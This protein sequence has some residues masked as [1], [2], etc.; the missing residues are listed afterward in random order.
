MIIY[1]GDNE[2]QA[3]K[4]IIG[5]TLESLSKQD[6]DLYYLDCDL[7]NSCGTYGFWKNNP[8]R[9]INCGISEANMVGVAAGLSLLGKKVYAHTFGPFASRRCY[10]QLFLSIGYSNNNLRLIGSDP[11]VTAAYNGGTHMPFEDMA[12]LRAI[13][14]STVIEVSSGVML[15]KILTDI[16]DRQ[17][18]T[19]I[20]ST[21]KSYKVLYSEDQDFEIGK[22][23]VLQ[24][25]TDVTIVACGLMVSESMLAAKLLKDEGI[26][27]CVVDM[28]TV[29]PIDESLVIDCAKKT[30][31]L[32]TC[33]NHN[34]VGGLS[35]A[36]AKVLFES[37]TLVP[38]ERIGVKESFGEVGPQDYL[39][40]RFGLTAS[41]IVEAVKR[42]LS[43]KPQ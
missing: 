22:G 16:K 26:N 23:I 17:G 10:D 28:F 32:V 20:R 5:A 41:D 21:R 34:V 6:K 4:D 1:N 2:K 3:Y 40:K 39:Q 37:N 19:Y 27:A 15:K 18:L 25:G 9:A 31:A 33:E 7:M 13:P 8:K 14:N 35:D 43:N 38:M 24:E 11:G 29:K 30:G 12:L 36:V 42:V